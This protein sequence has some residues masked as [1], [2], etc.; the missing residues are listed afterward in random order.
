M[1][2]PV[3]VIVIVALAEELLAL[4]I[5]LATSSLGTLALAMEMTVSLKPS[6]TKPAIMIAKV[7]RKNGLFTPTSLNPIIG[8]TN[9][10]MQYP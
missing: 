1:S 7:I 10:K 2:I 4:L 5:L 6:R 9:H 8:W 3:I